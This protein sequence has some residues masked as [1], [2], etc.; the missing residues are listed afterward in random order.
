MNFI[1]KLLKI[2]N[3]RDISGYQLEKATGIKQATL[4]KWKKGSL[5]TIDKLVTLVN[6]FQVSSDEL[7]DINIKSNLTENEQ[8]LLEQF[9]KLSERDQIKFIGRIEEFTKERGNQNE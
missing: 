6:Y 9:R 8:E 1:E 4:G 3:E 7:L 5:P 2:M